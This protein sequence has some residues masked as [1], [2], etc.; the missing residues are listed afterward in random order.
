[1]SDPKIVAQKS[2]E[3]GSVAGIA[4]GI[5]GTVGVAA[6]GW[7]RA[8]GVDIPDA[9]MIAAISS[10]AAAVWHGVRNWLKHRK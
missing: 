6:A 10:I 5:A 7:C 1:M 9:A 4:A 3:G 2:F 8:K